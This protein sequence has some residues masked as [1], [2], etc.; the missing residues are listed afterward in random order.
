MLLRN[1]R[2]AGAGSGTGGGAT[3]ATGAALVD[4]TID[5][6]HIASI[7]PA[8]SGSVR[9]LESI[10]LDGRW[11]MPGLWDTHVHFTQ[12][13]LHRS[14]LD[15]SRVG[16]AA[17][18]ASVVAAAARPEH[19]FPLV[20]AGFQDGLW[21]DAPTAALL[22]AVAPDIAVVLVSHDL[23]S[24]W[25]NSRALERYAPT[26]ERGS[27]LHRSGLL[28]EDDC[29]AVM[30]QLDDV[31][32][33]VLDEWV[34]HAAAEAA[35][36]GVVGVIDMEMAWNLETWSRRQTD[37]V[38]SLRVEFGIYTQHLDRAIAEGLRSGDRISELLTVGPFKIIT[39]GSL[40]TRTAYCYDA[41]PG[42]AVDAHGLLTVAPERL[43][44]LMAQA[45]AGR[46][47][48]AVHAIG[49]H[50]N[51][52]ALDAFDA[53]R[54]PGSIEHAQL[55]SEVDFARFAALGVVASV[56]PEHAMDDREV[57]DRYWAGRTERAFA[58]RSLVDA[59]AR[60]TL[61]S[62]AP[63]APLD[64]WV[65]IAAAVGRGRDGL[66][67]WHPEQGLSAAEAIE[68]SVRTRVAEGEVA[69]LVVTELDPYS[70]GPDSLR[71]MPVALTMLGGRL[72][73]DSLA[74]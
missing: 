61:G 51:A 27:E 41:Y 47:T 7:V 59:G 3:A 67:P 66:A 72:T 70:G 71:S 36:R 62:D 58:L 16:S 26:I 14:R 39:D 68:A 23:H 42:L 2:I 60:I 34:G 31:P 35:S 22:D 25:V 73:H 24:C 6:G 52:L 9:G 32:A 20:G 13:A 28:R 30:R 33:G 43:V 57:A 50:A 48:P 8:A 5:D 56:Q 64:P 37:G 10:D 15:L 55:V 18:A 74:G 11:L 69:D 53:V 46:I 63:V 49:D 21:P 40:N 12:W 45:W 54:C 1:A 4:V 65:A 44:E 17:E 19:G 38:D 29:F